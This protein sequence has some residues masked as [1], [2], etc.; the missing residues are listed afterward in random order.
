MG[1]YY[2][3]AFGIAMSTH[4]GHVLMTA[5]FLT[6]QPPRQ[7]MG[8]QPHRGPIPRRS[9]RVGGSATTLSPSSPPL[10]RSPGIRSDNRESHR[11]DR[12][13]T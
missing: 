5:H 3:L 11:Y 6:V 7:D 13:P 4:T 8:S 10:S 2:T 1:F 12:K 9:A